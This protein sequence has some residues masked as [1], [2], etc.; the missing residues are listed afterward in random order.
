M[1]TTGFNSSLALPFHLLLLLFLA[2]SG[3]EVEGTTASLAYPWSSRRRCRT[4]AYLIVP[5]PAGSARC[6]GRHSGR[7]PQLGKRHWARQADVTGLASCELARGSLELRLRCRQCQSARFDNVFRL[8]FIFASKQ[9]IGSR[10]APLPITS[11]ADEL[12]DKTR[13]GCSH[14]ISSLAHRL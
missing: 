3:A 13:I 5:V 4:C 12:N 1:V 6:V 8:A 2:G 11:A 14:F 9:D 7:S 10:S